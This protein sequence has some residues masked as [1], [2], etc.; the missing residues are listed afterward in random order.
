MSSVL[1]KKQIFRQENGESIELI[2]SGDEFYSQLRTKEGYS[3]IYD[4]KKEGYCYAELKN[5]AFVTSGIFADGNPPE[6]LKKNLQE[7]KNVRAE[8]FEKRFRKIRGYDDA[9]DSGVFHTLGRNRGLLEGE[10]VNEGQV[11]GLTVL[12]EFADKNTNISKYD[13]DAMLNGDR[14]KRNGNYCSVKEYFYLMSNGKL[15][16]TNT[17]VGPIKLSEKKSYYATNLFV[18]EALEIV[19]NQENIRLSDF[20]SK[21]RNVV[22]ALN[23]LFAGEAI[24]DSSRDN[25]W[26]HNGIYNFHNDGIRTH[27]YQLT[28]LG[29]SPANLAIG[30]FCHENGHMLCRFPDLY[31]Y[32]RRDYNDRPSRGMGPYCLMSYGNKL[33][34][35]KV[36]SPI[37]AYLRYLVNWHNNEINIGEPGIYQAKHGDYATIFKYSTDKENEY[38]LVENRAIYD[39]DRYLPSSG[40]AIYHCDINGSN[41]WEG[42]TV[43]RHYQC[44]LIQADGRYDL[45][46]N[47]SED[48]NDLYAEVSGI[49]LSDDTKPSSNGWDGSSSGLIISN[50]STPSTTISFQTGEKPP[51][52]PPKFVVKKR[53]VSEMS[54]PDHNI[55]GIY[56]KDINIQENGYLKQI[57]I[58][59]KITHSN[60]IDLQ[61]VIIAPSG[62]AIM[63]RN[64]RSLSSNNLAETYDFESSTPENLR[65]LEDELI[66][67][68]WYL[69]IRDI[70]R[71]DIGTLNEWGIEIKYEPY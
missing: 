31:D 63:L 12:V 46:N 65:L 48:A 4:S 25:L 6:G 29:D 61:V 40:L 59:V 45:E 49:A 53:S 38:F 42:G 55:E 1:E 66:S 43:D 57:S 14:Y 9:I 32:G 60:M 62:K 33:Y 64:C 2:V 67:G 56:S 24:Y 39:L 3:A 70:E 54:I 51:L 44:A 20:D 30:T 23:F 50:I 5:G 36:P 21:G 28:D 26:P 15:E 11:R 35:N 47:R 58:D 27:F 16:Y 10:R 37:C 41:E 18:Q 52:P 7:D 68:S 17:V 19:V 22:D 71:G 69:Y 34:N 13:V 8:K